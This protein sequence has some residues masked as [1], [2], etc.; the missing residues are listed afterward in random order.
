MTTLLTARCQNLAPPFGLHS[1][2]EAMGLMAPAHFG[3]K[4]AF[5]QRCSSSWP[6]IASSNTPH[7]EPQSLNP[8]QQTIERFSLSD[9]PRSVKPRP[10][11]VHFAEN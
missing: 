9:A 7:E 2:A 11:V 1:G 5:G 3:L 10:G 6:P 4:G 8:P